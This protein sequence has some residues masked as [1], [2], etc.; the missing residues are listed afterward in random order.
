MISA[1]RFLNKPYPL[2]DDL[3]HNAKIVLFLSIGVFAFLS[4]FQPI[5]ISAFSRKVI[6]YL[7]FGIAASLFV[8]L[9]LNLIVLPS[10]FPRFFNSSRWNIK[11]EIGWNLWMLLSISSCALLVYSKILGPTGI[12]FT[13]VLKVILIG[14]VPVALLIII[15]YNRM[16]RS[17]LKSA[18]LLNQKL[19]EKREQNRRLIHFVSEYKN[20][21]ITLNPES[22][23]AIKSADNYVD[24]YY[25]RE[26][27]PRRHTIRSTLNKAAATTENCG[28]L[29][30]CH[31]S[32]IVNIHRI[33]E[34][35]GNSQGYT[36]YI[37]NLDFP[38]PVSHMYI[39]EFKRL[40]I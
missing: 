21:E 33:T 9:T 10:V 23:L 1:L 19:T 34:V 29:F 16:L 18:Q 35:Q 36:L 37:E 11:R 28:F 7:V 15:N 14:S 39:M 26:G 32:F 3:K 25:E 38:V 27:T 8:I 4:L 22:I 24:I 30:R 20:D 2:N 6:I 12:V 17:N 31:R 5:G 13:D 40:L